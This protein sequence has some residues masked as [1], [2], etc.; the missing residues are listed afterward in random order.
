MCFSKVSG[1]TRKRRV[2]RLEKSLIK[3]SE[4]LF[5]PF[6]YWGLLIIRI[7]FVDQFLSLFRKLP[8][9]SKI[10]DPENGTNFGHGNCF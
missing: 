1:P 5:Y 4:T 8:V 10:Q 9:Y 6:G 3:R 7:L 2:A